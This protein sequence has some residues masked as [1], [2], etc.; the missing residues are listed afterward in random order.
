[1]S[2]DEPGIDPYQP[3]FRIFQGRPAT[4]VLVVT[5]AGELDTLTSP[6]LGE[7]LRSTADDAPAHVIVDLQSVTFFSSAA[8]STVLI[9][10]AQVSAAG[11]EL[12]LIG[13]DGNRSV[14]RVLDITGLAKSFSLHPTVA[15]ALADIISA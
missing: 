11:G 13:V 1:M 8:V 6:R 7:T 5:V 14:A 12:H 4:G 9:G 2:T 10:R 15:D 3:P